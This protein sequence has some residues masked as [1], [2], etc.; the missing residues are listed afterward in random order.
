[1]DRSHV[2]VALIAV[3]LTVGVCLGVY[4]GAL[5][6]DGTTAASPSTSTPTPTPA[7]ESSLV[8]YS[9]LSNADTSNDITAHGVTLQVN[10]GMAAGDVPGTGETAISSVDG[11]TLSV[12]GVAGGKVTDAFTLSAWMW[13]VDPL[14]SGGVI[15][16]VNR[17]AP[18]HHDNVLVLETGQVV[19]NRADNT[20]PYETWDLGIDFTTAEWTHVLL[21]VK[22]LNDAHSHVDLVVDGD[23]TQTFAVPLVSLEAGDFINVFGEYDEVTE[24]ASP[25]PNGNYVRG[26]VRDMRLYNAFVEG[27]PVPDR[28]ID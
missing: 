26:Y 17:S 12:A 14:P 28:S 16:G 23:Y 4:Y 9:K 19:C 11:G 2:I 22:P 20:S 6:C 8:Y 7:A 3:L 21:R 24:G 5:Q 27:I 13:L 10:D 1:M 25:V 15:F 18:S